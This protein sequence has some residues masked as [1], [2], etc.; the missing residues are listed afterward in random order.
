MV[1]NETH[2]YLNFDVT[3]IPQELISELNSEEA[4]D[5][6]LKPNKYL[7]DNIRANY[8]RQMRKHEKKFFIFCKFFKSKNIHS[9]LAS[10]FLYVVHHHC[11]RHLKYIY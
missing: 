1:L 11:N 6:K 10:N 7:Y 2:L 3:A 8:L 4:G 9:L 5:V